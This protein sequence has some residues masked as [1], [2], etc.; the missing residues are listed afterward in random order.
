MSKITI[1][2]PDSVTDRMR[3]RTD[4]QWGEVFTGAALK[5][6]QAPQLDFPRI[7]LDENIRGLGDPW[8]TRFMDT[9]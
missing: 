4:I 9:L 7:T 2:L 5:A 3:E 1:T 8:N 6:M